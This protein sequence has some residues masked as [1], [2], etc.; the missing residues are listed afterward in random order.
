MSGNMCAG[1][2]TSVPDVNGLSVHTSSLE[3]A[4]SKT[5]PNTCRADVGPLSSSLC[6]NLILV[7]HSANVP[8][9]RNH[10]RTSFC[11]M[12]HF[13]PLKPKHTEKSSPKMIYYP[14]FPSFYF[15]TKAKK[16]KIKKNPLSQGRSIIDCD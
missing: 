16:K 2:A 15:H 13:P 11:F 1:S 5:P 9:V 10:S 8:I 7:C 4:Q 12:K 6:T 14:K 3:L